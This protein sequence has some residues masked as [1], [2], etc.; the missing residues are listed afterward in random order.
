MSFCNQE[1]IGK[2]FEYLSRISYINMSI[3]NQTTITDRD[4]EHLKNIHNLDMDF[5]RQTTIT[6]YAFKYLKIHLL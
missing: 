1:T 2:A 6:D 5:C 4:F 3:C